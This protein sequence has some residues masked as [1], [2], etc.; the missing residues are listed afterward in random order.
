MPVFAMHPLTADGSLKRGGGLALANVL[1]RIHFFFGDE[2]GIRVE[3]REGVGA[4]GLWSSLWANLTSRTRAQYLRPLT[5][6]NCAG[7]S[8][9]LALR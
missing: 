3:S 1:M 2:S 5:L 7:A 4:R 6:G 9:L 8:G